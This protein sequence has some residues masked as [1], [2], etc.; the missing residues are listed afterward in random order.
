MTK[1][2][3]NRLAPICLIL[4][5][6]GLPL[7][8]QTA[9]EQPDPEP[10]EAAEA[11]QPRLPERKGPRSL[12]PG[13]FLPPQAVPVPRPEELTGAD[14]PEAAAPGLVQPDQVE[15]QPLD[16]LGEAGIG[17]LPPGVALP[18]DL[19]RRSEPA[20]ASGLLARLPQGMVSP[21]GRALMRDL[22]LS[23]ALPP[24]RGP[25]PDALTLRVAALAAAGMVDDALALSGQAPASALEGRL[26]R[27]RT[28]AL[29]AGG[30]LS[31]ACR[32]IQDGLRAQGTAFWLRLQAVC[33]ALTG[34]RSG[35]Y[36]QLNLLQENGEAGPL[37]P[38]LI[39]R[40]LAPMEDGQR[41]LPF[42][43]VDRLDWALFAALYGA[44]LAPPLRLAETAE[45]MMLTELVISPALDSASRVQ[46]AETALA[47]GVLPGERLANFLTGVSF[48]ARELA[49]AD[50]VLE[51]QA[52]ISGLGYGSLPLS[53]LMID[54][55][56]FQRTVDA[57]D[58]R[59]ALA[60]TQILMD[61]AYDGG[62]ALAMAQ[63]LAPVLAPI[64]PSYPVRGSAALTAT[65]FYVADRPDRADSWLALL[66]EGSA[67]YARLWPLRFL[68]ERG[69]GADD[70]LAQLGRWARRDDVTPDRLNLVLALAEALSAEPLPPAL[71]AQA[72]R[73][74]DG[75]GRHTPPVAVWRQLLIAEAD[76][77]IG[78]LIAGALSAL[79]GQGPRDTDPAA[80]SAALNAIMAA[81]REDAAR[82]LAV[83]ALIAR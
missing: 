67:A 16:R 50:L 30:R 41:P 28:E 53:G 35:A 39:D 6:F 37:L 32:L 45:P 65:I 34:N 19:W 44:S 74:P 31:D 2:V 66:D 64:A 59:I 82:R 52:A 57:T 72:L 21:T 48:E 3:A 49:S 38:R 23:P 8:A 68:T 63:A 80:L 12:T 55:L 54:A 25:I 69:R 5:V 73:G 20:V 79:G 7:A 26:L 70:V 60:F 40:L 17:T 29:V 33:Q 83:E 78:E 15:A 10:E 76:N 24:E 11:A 18:V 61:R 13:P 47:R 42:D 4:A 46:L 22:L 43:R 75:D 71:W 56:L 9:P 77:R 36:F 81:G 1:P 62:Y 58:P 51:D 14:L 27:L